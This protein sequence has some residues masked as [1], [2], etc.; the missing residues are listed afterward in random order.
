MLTGN[1]LITITISGV[2]I[3]N[4]Q[5]RSS[6]QYSLIQAEMS[7]MG[8]GNYHVMTLQGLID[9]F[10]RFDNHMDENQ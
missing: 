7:K 9:K 1:E 6:I 3:N 8:M 4:D 5:K 10:D 2:D